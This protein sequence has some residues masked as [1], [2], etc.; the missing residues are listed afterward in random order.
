MLRKVRILGGVVTLAVLA[1]ATAGVAAEQTATSAAA[2]SSASRPESLDEVTIRARRAELARKVS[3]FV[4]QIAATENAEGL[5]RWNEPVC[6]L[7]TGLPRQEGEFIL[8]RVSQ[9]AR[10]TAVPLAGERCRPNLYIVVTSDPKK[11]LEGLD[12]RHRLLVF[13][14]TGASVV[15]DFIAT[16]RAVRVWYSSDM[17]DPF[18]TPPDTPTVFSPCTMGPS[19]CSLPMVDHAD[20]THLSFNRIWNFSRVVLIVDQTRLHAV[21]R[22]QFADYA[23]MVG[24][25]E[26][27]PDARLDDAETILK[28]FDAAPEAAPAGM[29]DWDRVFLKSLYA[30]EQRVRQ[31]RSEIAHNIVR[32]IAR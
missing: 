22:G 3:K 18:G 17:T 15:H 29:T 32:Q 28:L 9:I 27:R 1:G 14:G 10:A 16:P 31:Q 2:T 8:E 4:N 13:G 11:A 21:A 7:V 25:A 26:I 6:P 23:A 19:I 24:L 20:P 12:H 5:P 30:T